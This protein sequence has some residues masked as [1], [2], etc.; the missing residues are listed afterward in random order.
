MEFPATD[1]NITKVNGIILKT[2]ETVDEVTALVE[3][4][5]RVSSSEWFVSVVLK[6]S[7]FFGREK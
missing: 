3:A 2:L 4:W 6:R 7:M 5:K 1:A